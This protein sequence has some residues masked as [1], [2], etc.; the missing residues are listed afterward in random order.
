YEQFFKVIKILTGNHQDVKRGFTQM[1]FN[2][3]SIN[4]DDHVK[5]FAFIMADNGEWRLSPA[6][7]LTFATGP[8]GEHSM[9]ILNEGKSPKKKDIQELGKRA[10]LNITEMNQSMEKVVTAVQKWHVFAQLAGVNEKRGKDIN[11]VICSNLKAFFD[12]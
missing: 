6:Y 5:N 2:V 8:G 3:L 4:R 9:T 12:K 11:S 10:G 1:I 7:D